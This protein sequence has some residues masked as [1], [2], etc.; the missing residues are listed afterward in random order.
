MLMTT[1]FPDEK[2]DSQEP[3]RKPLNDLGR[4][5]SETVVLGRAATKGDIESTLLDDVERAANQRFALL[6]SAI[7]DILSLS[8]EKRDSLN[9]DKKAVCDWIGQYAKALVAGSVFERRGEFLVTS[10]SLKAALAKLA[11][12]EVA[13]IETAVQIIFPKQILQPESL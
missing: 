6:A 2:G 4:Q 11:P 1:E 13:K 5:R 9:S 3:V 10:D 8:G 12:E 7:I